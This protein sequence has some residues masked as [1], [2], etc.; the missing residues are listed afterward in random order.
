MDG[1]NLV[2]TTGRK[3]N[4][5]WEKTADGKTVAF[6]A[7]KKEEATKTVYTKD[8]NELSNAKSGTTAYTDLAK[9]HRMK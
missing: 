8:S 4:G 7:S 1:S 3:V 9:R 2:E 5:S 6:E